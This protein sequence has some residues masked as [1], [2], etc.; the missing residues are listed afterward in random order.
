[1]RIHF[2]TDKIN[3]VDPNAD[4]LYP[5]L[6]A[7]L[8]IIEY[9]ILQFGFWGREKWIHIWIRMWI[10]F[11][12]DKINYADPKADP[13]YPTPKAKLYIIEY[14]ILQFGFWGRENW[15]CIWI[16]MIHNGH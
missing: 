8:Y 5:T 16:Y 11:T 10:H 7:K 4:P 13:L 2:T 12:T 6:K 3:Y 1:M 14:Y 9:Y 15:I